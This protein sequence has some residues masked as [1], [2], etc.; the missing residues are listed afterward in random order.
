MRSDGIRLVSIMAVLALIGAGMVCLI[1]D[2]DSSA[3]APS[4]GTASNPLTSFNEEAMSITA[5]SY[6][7][8]LQVGSSFNLEGYEES[9]RNILSEISAPNASSYGLYFSGTDLVGTVS[10]AGSLTVNIDNEGTALN[11]NKDTTLNFV[12]VDK[13][14]TVTFSTDGTQC[15]QQSGG[16]ITLPSTSKSGYKFLGW[17]KSDDSRVGGAGSSYTPSQ[18]ITLYAKWESTTISITSSSGAKDMVR[19]SLYTHTLSSNISG[20]TVSV[21]GA[22]WLTASGYTISGV[23]PVAGDY[24]VTVTLSKSGYTSAS[25]SFTIHVAE[26]L[27]FK[28]SPSAGAIVKG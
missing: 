9:L 20:C 25:Q 16:K 6:T 23:P 12:F 10:K 3:V 5:G 11:G 22:D 27:E 19:S 14:Y 18:N 2:D 8:Y 13:Q 1:T 21:S 26:I 28:S 17:Y 24:N 7:I 4:T 15:P